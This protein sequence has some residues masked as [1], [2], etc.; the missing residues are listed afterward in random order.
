M[1][2]ADAWRPSKYVFRRGRLAASRDRK[3]VGVA[4]RLFTNLVA[5]FYDRGIKEH[6]RGRLLDLGCGFVPLYAAYKP[7]VAE[8]VCVDWENTL[9]KN[10]YLDFGCDLTKPLP[11][12]DSQFDTIILSDV[13]EHMPEPRD[14]WREMARVLTPGGKILL[15][16][17]FYYWLHEQPYDYY[18]YTEFALTRFVDDAGLSLVQLEPLGGSP[19]VLADLMAKMVHRM[20][21]IGRGLAMA[22][23]STTGFFVGTGVGRKVSRRSG[24]TF[25]IGYFLVAA[26]AP[27]EPDPAPAG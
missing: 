20:P 25:P 24:R 26:K 18:R 16:V 14:L 5:G 2:N 23:Q 10:S 17:P 4:S 3:E 21:L 15:S 9:H 11:F 1:K 27:L 19:E 7:Y 22:V 6:A 12:E 8:N 13:L